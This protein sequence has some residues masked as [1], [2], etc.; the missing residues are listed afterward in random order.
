[1]LAFASLARRLRSY[2]ALQRA[3]EAV[4]AAERVRR[5]M[6][7][8][9]AGPLGLAVALG[10][11]ILAVFVAGSW[12]ERAR[13][14]DLRERGVA[15]LELHATLL[16]QE[17]ARYHFLPAAVQLNPTVLAFL[18]D[19]QDTAVAEQV[20]RFL[21]TLNA[22]AGASE[23]YVLDR[24]GKVLAASNWDEEIS[25]VGVDLSYRPYFQDA[26]RT[27]LGRFYGIGTTS[28]E[29]GYYYAKAI[30]EGGLVLGVAT[31]KVS[32]DKLQS[33]WRRSSTQAAMAVDGE[34]V[35]ILASEPDW[36]YRTLE[37]LPRAT[38][39]R[40]RAT[41]QFEDV[42]LEPLGIRTE[43]LLDA[44]VRIIS[45][46]YGDAGERHRFLL[47]ERV[48]APS[49]WRMII[50]SDL[51]DLAAATR[52]AQALAGLGFG[53]A[54]LLVLFLRQ[55]RR[56]IRLELAAK[57]TLE[58]A[59][60]ELERKVAE[61]TRDLL[62]AQDK[63]VHA[64]RLAALGQMA[65]VVAH[66]LNQ[67]LAALRTLSDNA[68]TLLRRGRA[69]ETE[70]NLGMIAQIVDRMAKIS[71]QLKL[72]A[73]KPKTVGGPVSIGPC[74]EHALALL[75]P[76]LR[77]QGVTVTLDIAAAD[78]QAQADAAR[79]EQVLVNLLG[80]ALDALRG[81]EGGRIEVSAG[82]R[83]GRRVV[84][85]VRDDGPGIPPELLPRLFEPFFTT[86][87]TG[88]GLG[89]GLTISEGIVGELGGTLRARN[90]PERGRGVRRRAAGSD[91]GGRWRCLKA[92]RS[93]SSRTTPPCVSAACRR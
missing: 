59:N 81:Q 47:Q 32:L 16:E 70:G 42:P 61:R 89:L 9:P 22:E 93:C 29:P 7:A 52:A 92:S 88:S 5:K 67:P 43:R 11:F 58:H 33:P 84:I 6:P 36:K 15:R 82:S 60:L 50:L 38:L 48:L 3:V 65:A 75:E 76:R 19:P 1:M 91:A 62:A 45:L 51:E 12:T 39:D 80:N 77:D 8:L 83:D 20:G 4:R 87:E 17:L 41:R 13:L 26:L 18:R 53:S 25:F 35:V 69:S 72:F 14:A 71:N 64:S 56:V 68:V 34:G 78:L 57:K 74:L 90:R 30:V 66:E 49:D 86:K 2:L 73:S 44:G 40:V 85:S 63:L 23:L 79:L 28:G 24:A 54:T 27:G 46:P 21:G 10:L 37:P 55:R 31:V